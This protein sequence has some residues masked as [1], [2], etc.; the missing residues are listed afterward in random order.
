MKRAVFIAIVCLAAWTL[1]AQTPT[2][3][4][5]DVRL[6]NVV[7]TVTD[8]EGRFVSNLTAD[9]FE[10]LEDGAPQ[11]ITHF[12]QDR[13]T[14][15]SVGILLDTSGS[16]AAKMRTAIEAIDRFVN[17]VHKDDD[18]FVMTFAGK[19]SLEQDFTNDRKK[20]S[21]AL[22][23]LHIGGSTLLYQALADSLEK[24]QH[25]NHDK[26]AILVLSDGFDSGSHRTPLADVL[27]RIQSSE[28][29]VYGLGTAPTL[30]AD[31]NEHIPFTLPTPATAARRP[32]PI[33]N[34]R[35]A[36]RGRGAPAVNA[37]NGVN[38]S[39][40][41]QFGESSG[42]NAFLLSETFIN[43]GASEIDRVLTLIADELRGQ[44]TLSYYPSAPDNGKLHTV[45]VTAK[46]GQRV[47]ARSGYQGLKK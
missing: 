45:K 31:P 41:N 10:V 13:D 12:T 26:R 28:V 36:G 18:I 17:N 2:R 46:G 42:G 20:L 44:Y 32:A 24:I 30:Y 33:A 38:M 25:G 35:P 22:N 8:A 15:V 9:D 7:A 37:I 21:R 6:I 3:L 40:M 4:S 16:M 23:S 5:V 19:I 29:L 47:R 27:K 39:V 34:P 1:A 43:D 11:K 14:P